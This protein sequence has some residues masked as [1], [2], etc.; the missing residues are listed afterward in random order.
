VEGNR[1]MHALFVRERGGRRSIDPLPYELAWIS[2]KRY[3]MNSAL[4]LILCR[5]QESVA[6]ASRR[7]FAARR[8]CK[9][10]QRDAGA[11]SL[12]LRSKVWEHRSMY[13]DRREECGL[14]VLWFLA[15]VSKILVFSLGLMMCSLSRD[16]QKVSTICR[17]AVR[18]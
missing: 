12:A 3:L 8:T 13:S 18:E 17:P 9:N 6:P 10:R 15:V 14:V 5:E 4:S 7:G 16:W 1:L 2:H 11:T